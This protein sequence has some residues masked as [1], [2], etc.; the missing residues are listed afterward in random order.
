MTD[1]LPD[2]QPRLPQEM[3]HQAMADFFANMS[4]ELRTPLNAIIGMAYLV[5]QSNLDPQ[6]RDNMR[7]I[8][9][10][11][12]HLLGII[13][14]MLDYTR[15]EAGEIVFT[16]AV[17]SPTTLLED[18]LRRFT[19]MLQAKGLKLLASV[20][21]AVPVRLLGDSVRIG[22]I[23]GQY[24]EN[25][26]KFTD[27]GWIEV[28]L[29]ADPITSGVPPTCRLHGSVRDTGIGMTEAQR[30]ELFQA[31]RQVDSSTS[32]RFGGTGLGLAIARKLAECM[33]GEVGVETTPNVGSMFRFAVNLEVEPGTPLLAKAH[34]FA[35]EAPQ[36][37]TVKGAT[38][39]DRQELAT[40]TASLRALLAEDDAE[41][42]E[43]FTQHAALL[44]TAW[45]ADFARLEQAIRGFD[46]AQ[47]LSILKQ[48]YE[49]G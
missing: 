46:F 9:V 30:K 20:E 18:T 11:G 15:L 29:R 25:A 4:H 12:Q 1:V 37:E 7:K 27:K 43:L 24:V 44:R 13:D 42:L 47:A 31:F 3:A 45:P 5:L 2:R 23:I 49:R 28:T 39:I 19:D 6:Q 33:G 48:A 35:I 10:A 22:Q 32:R 8:E 36:A 34:R 21:P 40:V 41:A 26:I 14:D 38:S 16:R 17:F